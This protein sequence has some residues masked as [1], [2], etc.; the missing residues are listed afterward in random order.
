[1][2][3]EAIVVHSGGMDSSICLAMAVKEFGKE[4]VLG[5]SFDYGQ[6]HEEELRRSEEICKHF[7]VDHITLSL[8]CLSEITTNALMDKKMEIEHKKG[9]APNTLVV[10]RNGLMAR[11]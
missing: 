1:L 6:R 8:H 5:L 3:K 2:K 10:G 7:G 4:N 11:L 9:E